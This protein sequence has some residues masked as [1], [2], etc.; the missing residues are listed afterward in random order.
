MDE[1]KQIFGPGL[2]EKT[3]SET[4]PSTATPSN[5]QPVVS[6]SSDGTVPT[7]TP[8]TS[9]ASYVMARFQ[10]N[11][12]FRRR[13][14]T[15]DRL[16]YCLRAQ[17]CEFSQEQQDK[18]VAMFGNRDLVSR[19]FVPITSV[20]NRAAKAMLM[21]LVN[22]SGSPLFRIEP[23][24]SPDVSEEVS[25]SVL[26][27]T[28]GQ[29]DSLFAEI[30]QSGMTQ[31]PPEAMAKIQGLVVGL[32]ESRYDDMRNAEESYARTRAR[33]LEK[34][35]WDI[36]CEGGFDEAFAQYIDNICT[37]GT[38]VML[39]PIVR[40]VAK[41]SYV[42]NKKSGERKFKRIVKAVPTFESVNPQDCYPAPDAKDVGD[43]AFCIT[44]KYTADSLWRFVS[45]SGKAGKADGD[46]WISDT[47][48]AILERHPRGGIRLDVVQYNPD[49]RFCENNGF[50]DSADCT[51]E[52]VRC[53]ATVR[54]S[55]LASMGIL[56]NRDCKDIR[57][58]DFYRTE[59][60]VIDNHVVFCRVYDSTQDLPVSKGCFY[61]LPGS[62]W[63]ES[64]ADKVSV[65]QAT[66]NNCIKALLLNMTNAAGP[67]W[68][69]KDVQRL[70]DKS[71]SAL[72]M[73]SGKTVAFTT[74][75]TGDGGAPI[76]AISVPSTASELLS[77]WAQM[78]K[79]AD[80][81]SGIPAY[82]EGQSAGSGG[83]LRTSSGLQTFVEQQMRGMKMV[84]G[85]TDR[86]IIVPTAR[87]TADW[88]ILNDDD[89][90]IKGDVEIR[91]VGLIGKI[92]KVQRDNA[93]VQLFN[94]ALNSQVLQQII[95]P[96]GLMELFRPSLV[97]LDIN[98]DDVIPSKGR[99]EE[100]A[101]IEGIRQIFQ[102]TQAA[103]GA[104][105]NAAHEGQGM[106]P[107]VQPPEEPQGGV[108]ERRG[109]A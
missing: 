18:L 85:E 97:D 75:L 38:G 68:W 100:M 45:N 82:T 58:N 22:Q 101:T 69:V 87:R 103:Q 91:S 46:G 86:G 5:P 88:V 23:T 28:V 26:E 107:G 4:A 79:Q 16:N 14:G 109:V 19:I 1:V 35:V 99:L 63:G 106:Q 15:S 8:M 84:I 60:I 33:R 20:K 51:F 40:N 54:G 98:P 92:L 34:K 49:R 72:K 80:F 52:G 57:I 2:D 47:V 50:V 59:T 36:M 64:I 24:P 37:Y 90:S 44:V 13:S 89:M 3:L 102:A 11:H 105:Q 74:S 81:D 76:G 66:L 39:G 21:D 83:A 62:W 65:C 32:T 53:F 10:E 12:D 78:Q 25:A 104:A 17:K 55:E 93:R 6:E 77:V 71:P 96:N 30:A 9:M 29:L 95:G 42:V 31:V 67:V 27:E 73:K 56:K 43:G 61:T 41:N 108:S 94:M 70:A 48:R 7:T